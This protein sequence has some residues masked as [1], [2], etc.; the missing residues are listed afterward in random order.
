MTA[1]RSVIDPADLRWIWLT[2]TDFDHIGA[3]PAAGREPSA[4]VATTFLS[5]GIMSLSAPLPLDRINLVNPGQQAHRGRPHPD[6]G[7]ATG[8]RQPGHHGLHDDKSGALVSSDC[9]GAPPASSARERGRPLRPGAAGGS[10]LGDPG[11]AVAPQGRRGGLRQGA[12]QHPRHG[13]LLVLSMP[14]GR[15]RQHDA[16]AAGPL[17]AAPTAQPFVGPDQAALEEMLAQMTGPQ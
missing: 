11:L 17:E 3:L 4:R 2:H 16:T 10:G 5:V 6:R 12:E 13:S 14:A 1:L 15:P 8:V 9:F 7:Q